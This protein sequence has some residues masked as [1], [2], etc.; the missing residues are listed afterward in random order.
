MEDSEILDLFFERSEQA[1]RELDHT[2]GAAVKKTAEN[3]EIR[4]TGNVLRYEDFDSHFAFF[5]AGVG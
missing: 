5:D 2:Y 1:I 3:L 4:P